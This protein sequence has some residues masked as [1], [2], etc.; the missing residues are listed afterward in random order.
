MLTFSVMD[1]IL[2]MW[3]VPSISE[4]WV[5]SIWYTSFLW[6][7]LMA[8]M[9]KKESIMKSEIAVLFVLVGVINTYFVIK[10]FLYTLSSIDPRAI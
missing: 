5:W 7:N 1:Y 2:S 6:D 10:T 8:L 4:F 3:E 9:K